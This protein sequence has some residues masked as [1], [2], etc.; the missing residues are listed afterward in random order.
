MRPE[1]FFSLFYLGTE[2]ETEKIETRNAFIKKLDKIS[3]LNDIGSD[4]SDN[5][6]VNRI[7]NIGD[8]VLELFENVVTDLDYP[9]L[10]II[11]SIRKIGKIVVKKGKE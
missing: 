5:E 1:H 8:E 9:L 4:G 3:E 2:D 7:F 11:K 6:V 10:L